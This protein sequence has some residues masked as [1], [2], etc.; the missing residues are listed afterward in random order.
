[1]LP[2]SKHFQSK[3]W[4]RLRKILQNQTKSSSNIW[5]TTFLATST[6]TTS[7]FQ[8]TCWRRLSKNWSR[9]WLNTKFMIFS[10]TRLS[11]R[12]RPSERR[13]NSATFNS[14]ANASQTLFTVQFKLLNPL[15]PK[16]LPK[17]N[18]QGSSCRCCKIKLTQ[19]LE[20]LVLCLCSLGD[21]MQAELTL[22]LLESC[23]RTVWLGLSARTD[24][25]G[26]A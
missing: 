10:F 24:C 7:R 14:Q 4:R 6:R 23:Y 26:K 19:L 9:S 21:P 2:S 25:K 5:V 22:I 20:R 16:S 3:C 12:L 18:S 17:H 15:T 8:S 1:M 11:S 13:S